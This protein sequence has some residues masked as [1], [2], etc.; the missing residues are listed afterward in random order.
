MHPIMSSNHQRWHDRMDIGQELFVMTYGRP[1]PQKGS[2]FQKYRSII[3]LKPLSIIINGKYFFLP[4][5]GIPF[6]TFLYVIWDMKSVTNLLMWIQLLILA[7]MSHCPYGLDHIKWGYFI[8]YLSESHTPQY[9]K[10]N[11]ALLFLGILHLSIWTTSTF[12]T[13][14]PNYQILHPAAQFEIL[15]AINT[16]GSKIVQLLLPMKNVQVALT[17]VAASLFY[18]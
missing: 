2:I 10:K 13:W 5:C 4:S 17:C 15:V 16:R 3:Q 18:I 6:T 1:K 11:L 7:V 9:G 12:A 8:Q 14:S